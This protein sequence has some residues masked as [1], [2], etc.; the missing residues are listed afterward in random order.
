MNRDQN[1]YQKYTNQSKKASNWIGGPMHEKRLQLVPGYAGHVPNLI[2]E[3]L[4]AKTYGNITATICENNHNKGFNV[5]EQKKFITS[6]QKEYSPS[7][8]RR[9]I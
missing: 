1:D 7:R 9:F 4:F 8:F 3:N 2:S 5:P 6:F